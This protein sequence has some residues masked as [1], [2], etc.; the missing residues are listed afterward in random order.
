MTTGNYPLVLATNATARMIIT[1]AGNVGIGSTGPAGRLDLVGT[2]TTSASVS[3]VIR[4]SSA[5]VNA[6]FRDNGNVGLGSTAPSQ[7]LDVVGT[8]KATAFIGDGSGISG[9]SGTISGLTPG[10]HTKASSATTI[11]NSL[12]YDNGTNVGIG[13]TVPQAKLDLEGSAYFGN[14][15]VGIGTTVPSE[16]FDNYGKARVFGHFSVGAEGGVD[17]NYPSTANVQRTLIDSRETVTDMTTPS[18]VNGL[19]SRM[20]LNPSVNATA[21]VYGLNFEIWTN[22]G[23]VRNVPTITATYND[24]VHNG[25]GTLTYVNAIENY[26][27]NKAA[28][29]ITSLFGVYNEFHSDGAGTIGDAYGVYTVMSRTAGTVTNAYGEY[30]GDLTAFGSSSYGLY[31]EDQATAGANK[32]AIYSA[33]GKSYHAGNFGIGSSA[34]QAKLDVEGSAYFGN[35]NIDVG[36]SAPSQK[37]DVLGTVKATAFIGDGSGLT[38]V[39]GGG[40][41]RTGTNVYV[42]TGTDNVGIG[43]SVPQT[44][45]DV[46]GTAYFNGN[47]GIG[48]ATTSYMLHVNGSAAGISWTNLSDERFKTNIRPLEG[49]LEKVLMLRGVSYEWKAPT[50]PHMKGVKLGVIAQAVEKV[51]PQA[52]TE[53]RAGVKGVD[54]NALMAPLIEAIREQQEE[55]RA[56]REEV[57][58]LREEVRGQGWPPGPSAKEDSPPQGAPGAGD[59]PDKAR[60]TISRRE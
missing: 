1:G 34:P 26:I 22:S 36:P 19:Y 21:S 50:E 38:G 16:L 35:G 41:T 49:S 32:F 37:V 43:S 13:S 45:L 58:Q 60:F 17:K 7:V 12:I 54:Y 51:Y 56:L 47:V 24:I 40:W 27:Y 15:N 59:R 6:T 29:N 18:F 23:N 55:I 10:Y 33:G 9:I 53:D 52:V 14:G 20:N 3:L 11:G 28:G 48:T 46:Q 25:T 8:V 57:E 5:A 39:G 2:G 30:I 4:N 44:K 31:L 42:M